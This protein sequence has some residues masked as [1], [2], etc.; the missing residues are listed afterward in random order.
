MK[1]TAI[2]GS[3]TKSIGVKWAKNEITFPIIIFYNGE[4][5]TSFDIFL[6]TKVQR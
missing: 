3:L 5:M 4:I 6:A 2:K 1:F